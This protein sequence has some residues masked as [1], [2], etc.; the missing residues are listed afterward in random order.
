MWNVNIHSLHINRDTVLRALE[1]SLYALVGAL[2]VGQIFT[3][4]LV[5]L[6]ESLLTMAG[7]SLLMLVSTA[8][9]PVTYWL[10]R[11]ERGGEEERGRVVPFPAAKA[12]GEGQEQ[13]D[14][15]RAA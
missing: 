8:S 3:A 5:T 7:A 14:Q 12:S 11:T 6:R 15:R 10:S 13:E 9:S 4:D 2:F 1:V